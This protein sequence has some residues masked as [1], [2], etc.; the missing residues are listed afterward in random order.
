MT[1]KV[2]WPQ[3]LAWRL[4][5]HYLDPIQDVS[6]EDVV[7]RLCGVQA[8]VASSA[9]MAVRVRQR[10][11]SP[12]EVGAALASGDLIKTWAMRGTLHYL[13]PEKAGPFL[14][15]LA[16]GKTWHSPTW[17]RYFGMSPD[18]IE[19]MLDVLGDVLADEPLTREEL[20][21]AV[22]RRPGLDHM[23]DSLRSGWGSVL[24]PLAWQG[25]LVFGPS[26]GQ[27]VTF[28][29]PERASKR[30]AGI[31]ALEDAAPAAID[32]YLAAYGP[33]TPMHFSAWISRGLIKK[34]QLLAWF[35]EM[36]D[37]LTT[38][39]VDGQASYIRTADSDAL[40][41]AKP[42]KAVRLL[43]GFDQW[44]LGP[45]TDD[46]HVLAPGRRAA[47]SRTA[48][49]IAPTVVRGGRVTGTW[50]LKGDTAVIGWFAEDGKPPAAAL[51]AEI[52]RYAAM[53]GRELRIE[54]ATV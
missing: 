27:R 33:A 22:T 1:L 16:S 26:Q 20:V 53:V 43:S 45:G 30:W 24:K 46:P 17:Q 42:T 21:E 54:I 39:E 49:W 11:S 51:A 3:A 37:R 5:R 9:E 8:Q 10:G 19:R 28:M 38:V 12:G 15:V 48:G 34:R 44:V 7:D 13:V 25:R 50:E 47:V 6:V 40:G 32:A 29:L 41:N 35:A 4:G 36:G 2:T 18:Q 31:P 23:A 52:G 14:S